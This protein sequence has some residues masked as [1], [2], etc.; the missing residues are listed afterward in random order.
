[1]EVGRAL[2]ISGLIGRSRAGLHQL[3]DAE[4]RKRDNGSKD[5]VC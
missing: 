3:R 4:K 2:A 5:D 1:M